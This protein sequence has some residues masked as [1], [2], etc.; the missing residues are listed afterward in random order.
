MA[1]LSIKWH[2]DP[3][4]LNRRVEQK[5]R[6]ANKYIHIRISCVPLRI[7]ANGT[8]GD[9]KWFFS[10]RSIIGCMNTQFCLSLLKRSNGNLIDF[11]RRG[12]GTPVNR[13]HLKA[14]LLLTSFSAGVWKSLRCSPFASRHRWSSFCSYLRRAKWELPAHEENRVETQTYV[15]NF[16]QPRETYCLL[17]DVWKLF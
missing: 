8:L 12:V 5:G 11:I 3:Q 13:V 2:P 4:T 6:S 16:E 9:F 15:A 17:R 7:E 10:I 14:H 1:F